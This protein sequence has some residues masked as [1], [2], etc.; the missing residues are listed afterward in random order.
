VGRTRICLRMID[1]E[2]AKAG[3]GCGMPQVALKPFV[4][5]VARKH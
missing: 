4:D 1:E 2:M 5:L 3:P